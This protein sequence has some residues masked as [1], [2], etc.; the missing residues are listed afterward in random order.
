[1]NTSINQFTNKMIDY[2]P[3]FDIM[4]PIMNIMKIILFR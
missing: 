1:M 2:R 4:K 3:T